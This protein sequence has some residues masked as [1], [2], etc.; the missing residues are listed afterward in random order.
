MKY[1]VDVQ[2]LNCQHPI[3]GSEF[4]AI[5]FR[6]QPSLGELEYNGAE[7]ALPYVKDPAQAKALWEELAKAMTELEKF[8][9]RNS[10]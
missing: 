8:I 1:P 7:F 5:R 9:W 3:E 2:C 4:L 10:D 6:L